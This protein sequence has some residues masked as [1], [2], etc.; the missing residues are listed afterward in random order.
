MI[1][2]INPIYT[3][4]RELSWLKFNERV[5]EEAEDET[6]PL[7][8]RLKFLAIFN[9]NLDE[10]YMI[11][12]GSL[13][14][15][16]LE[17]SLKFDN[18]SFLTPTQQ[19]E[20]IFAATKI[21]YKK[22]D[23]LAARLERVCHAAGIQR[24]KSEKLGKRETAFVKDYFR[25]QIMPLLSPLVINVRHPFPHLQNKAL[26]I[27]VSLKEK[28]NDIL[29]IIPIPENLPKLLYL[30]GRKNKYILLED[31]VLHYAEKIF[32]LYTVE[33][34]AVISVTRNADISLDDEDFELGE[35]YLQHMRKSLKR[36]GKLAAVRLEINGETC[37][38]MFTYLLEHL[39]IK[40]EQVFTCR[41][42]INLSYLLSLDE[43]MT[44][45]QKSTLMYPPFIPSSKCHIPQDTSMI[46]YIGHKDLLLNYPYQSFDLFL[47]LLKEAVYDDSVF[48]IKITIYR[49]GKR[50]AKLIQLLSMAAELGKDVTVL[51]EL[52]AR[53][54]EA[55][56]IN[57]AEMLQDAGCKVIYGVEGYKVHAK[58]CL[59][60]RRK[61]NKIEYITQIGTGNY[62]AQTAKLYTDLSFF[63]ASD[64]IGLDA[65]Q[66]FQNMGT[67]N[68]Q[69]NYNS[70]LSAPNSLKPDLLRLINE[71]REH[72]LAGKVSHILLKMN[73]LTDRDLIDA[74]ATASQAGVKIKM[75]IRGI[76]CIK[77]GIK[78]KT[79]NIK[80]ISIVG[81]FLEHSRIFCFGSG[82]TAK[83]Y[84]SS[85]DWMT[86]N[87]EHRVEIACPIYDLDLKESIY[88]S[89]LIMW[90]DTV[91][92]RFL[93]RDGDYEKFSAKLPRLDSQAFFLEKY[94]D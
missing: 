3:Q 27:A 38:S 60:M 51:M 17:K 62:N 90:R 66:F 52:R 57:W 93:N 21:L 40:K 53:F 33:K 20:K 2:K 87:T 56:N 69:G 15:L 42:P 19:L 71:Q 59:I 25:T 9:S 12:V 26:Y 10:F 79:E 63:T 89:L 78:G 14:D 43:R 68:L 30:P 1:K 58:I 76:C 88:Q 73:S 48:A 77:P 13:Y 80:V 67:D 54:D 41:T 84:I 7:Y 86:R 92:A 22:R 23:V 29:G 83:I 4:N 24:K 55:N 70:F 11:R 91:K 35:D 32:N 37:S 94:T 74:L 85:A 65:V 31:I 81:R 82:E 49:I 64:D 44:V 75:I 28:K 61:N 16:S 5:L 18:K 72:A 36:R 39:N 8:E 34:K 46:E 50:K 47:Q 45:E 6:V